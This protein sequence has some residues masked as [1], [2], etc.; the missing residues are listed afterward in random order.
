[1]EQKKGEYAELHD[2]P[3]KRARVCDQ[4]GFKGVG[5]ERDYEPGG[6]GRWSEGVCG[7]DR[8]RSGGERAAGRS[9]IREEGWDRMGEGQASLGRDLGRD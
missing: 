2:Q 5:H 4:R 8:I 3:G 1:V 9:V 7:I 6:D